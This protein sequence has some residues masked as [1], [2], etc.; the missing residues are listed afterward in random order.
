MTGLRAGFFRPNDGRGM[1]SVGQSTRCLL[2][3]TMLPL[4][5]VGA[6]IAGF[7]GYAAS[8]PS[9]FTIRRST[10]IKA[11]PDRIFPHLTD[12]RK[13]EAWSPWEKMD[14]TMKK[15]HTGSAS[16]KGAVYDWAGDGKVGKGRMEI[17]DTAAPKRVDIKLDFEKPFKASNRTV[18]SLEP[19]GGETEVTW[20]MSGNHAYMMKVFGVFMNMDKMVGKDFEKGLA[21]LKTVSESQSRP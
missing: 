9:D 21:S 10:R 4:L 14:P 11:P 15:T 13:W 7:F 8:R 1:L 3:A 5:A 20:A 6:V 16:G 19:Q 12:F 18:F 2:E 17:T